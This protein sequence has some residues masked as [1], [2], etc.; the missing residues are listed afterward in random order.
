MTSWEKVSSW[1]DKIVGKEGHYYHRRVIFPNLLRLMDLKEDE[2]YKIL[3]LGCGQGILSRLLPPSAIY[4]GVD[5]SPSLIKKAKKDTNHKFIKADATKKLSLSSDDFTHATIILA[6][7]NIEKPF[8]ALKN[9]FRHL[10]KGGKLFLVINHPCFRIPRQS[11]WEVDRENKRQYRR[12]NRYMSSLKIP[13][14]AHPGKGKKS[15][16]TYSFHHP[17][18]DYFGWLNEA[19]FVVEALEEWCSDKKST[20]KAAKWENRARKEFPL[21]L[22]IVASPGMFSGDLR[23][24]NAYSQ[25]KG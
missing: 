19:G 20:G 1:Y 23:E 10:K 21:F 24:P 14:Q 8:E 22:T 5:I 4:V 18:S 6:L 9:A 3:D 16:V 13:I 15:E 12:I 7:Q 11:S 17:L 2:E 25:K